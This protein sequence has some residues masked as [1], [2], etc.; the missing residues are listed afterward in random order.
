MNKLYK[1][2]PVLEL[3]PWIHESDLE[4]INGENYNQFKS[5]L[6][7]KHTISHNGFLSNSLK[8]SDL[9]DNDLKGVIKIEL[10][11]YLEDGLDV[12]EIFSFDGGLV[13]QIDKK[14]FFSHSVSSGKISHYKN[15][16]KFLKSNPKNWE[17][18]WIGRPWIYGRIRNGIIQLTDYR[19]ETIP[20]P[21]DDDSEILYQFE[22]DNFNEEINK[23]Q[24]LID[25]FR[26]RLNRA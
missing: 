6:L 9:R 25:E 13:L 1:I 5:R 4:I 21:N 24:K 7:K 16:L 22:L 23:A 17:E 11:D 12:S 18:I 3:N 20:K 2:E 14:T 26:W 15:W 10:I 8:I 19:D